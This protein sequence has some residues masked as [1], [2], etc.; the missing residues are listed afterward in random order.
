[1][2]FRFT[3]K[4]ISV[5]ISSFPIITNI[6]RAEKRK[7]VPTIHDCLNKQ[8]GKCGKIL[9]SGGFF[10]SCE[11]HFLTRMYVEANERMP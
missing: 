2:I 9:L 8:D 3:R 1:M 4:N 5:S 11:S 7:N 6:F 10:M